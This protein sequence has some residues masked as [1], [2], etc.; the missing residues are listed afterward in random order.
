V[1]SRR[2]PPISPDRPSPSSVTLKKKYF[3]TGGHRNWE[4]GTGPLTR[5]AGHSIETL[6]LREAAR[7]VLLQRSSADRRAAP[8]WE[9]LS[10][11]RGGLERWLDDTT[12]WQM[13][14]RQR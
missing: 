11:V 8:E 6:E 7:D 1:S 14:S 10:S 5:H 9:T 13:E 2:G 4:K 3:H 12:A